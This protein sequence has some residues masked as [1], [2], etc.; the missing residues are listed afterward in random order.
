MTMH[1]SIAG[2]VVGTFVLAGLCALVGCGGD[3]GDADTLPPAAAEGRAVY[4][5]KGCAACH[6]SDGGGQVGPG[7]VGIVGNQVELEDGP[8][9]VVDR[10]YLVESIVEPAAAIVEGYRLPMPRV[11]LTDAEVKSLVDYIEALSAPEAAS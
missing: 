5:D 1:P 8:A 10:D 6:G 7:L 9:V 3:G 11:D 4:L 2:K